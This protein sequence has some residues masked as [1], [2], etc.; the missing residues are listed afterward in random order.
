MVE[1]IALG[2][3]V[4]AAAF[5][6]LQ[7]AAA[8]KTQAAAEEAN[9]LAKQAN[10]RLDRQDQRTAVSWELELHPTYKSM[11]EF[12][13]TGHSPAYRVS[14]DLSALQSV[15]TEYLREYH[16]VEPGDSVTLN[17][18]NEGELRNLPDKIRISYS[19]Q[20]WGDPDRQSVVSLIARLPE[21]RA[22]GR[23]WWK[24]HVEERI[25]MD[26]QWQ[27]LMRRR[28]QAAASGVADGESPVPA[29]ATSHASPSP[30][31]PA[32]NPGQPPATPEKPDATD[33]STPTPPP[34]PP[35]AEPR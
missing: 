24:T 28:E 21:L 26:A 20:K 29:Q 17:L 31:P 33:D 16:E 18:V 4:A 5:T 3:A 11:L 27:D 32:G 30:M 13:N 34:S 15:R 6:G 12:R 7:A 10:D 1:L 9:R 23:E 19:L 35:P 25:V 2:V 8:V 14:F 22:I